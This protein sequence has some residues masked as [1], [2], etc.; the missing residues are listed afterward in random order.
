MHRVL[1]VALLV[2]A[3]E[4]VVAE[5][6]APGDVVLAGGGDGDV[7]GPDGPRLGLVTGQDRLGRRAEVDNQALE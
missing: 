5:R 6:P 7:A 4:P 2:A 1:K 3:G